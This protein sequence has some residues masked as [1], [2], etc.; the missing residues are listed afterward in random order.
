MS[1]Q[2]LE[3][4]TPRTRDPEAKR[5][6]LL[7]SARALFVEKGFE[8]STTKLIA[9]HAGVSEGVVF[10][11]F[12]SKQGL[13]SALVEE[14]S[15]ASAREFLLA[16]QG[17]LSPE[18]VV[19]NVIAFA[20]RDIDLF[21]MILDNQAMLKANGIPTLRDYLVPRIEEALRESIDAGICYPGD[22]EIMAR[23]QFSIVVTA[24]LG[25]MGSEDDEYKEALVTEAIRCMEAVSARVA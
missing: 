18:S 13:F 2:S 15:E 23:F 21:Q 16:E 22:P 8:G 7:A 19:R 9:A 17:S 3:R 10:H 1:V 24:L 6:N 20:E 11:Q 14:F 25:R 4:A 12:G 5:R